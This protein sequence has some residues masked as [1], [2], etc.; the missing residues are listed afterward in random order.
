MKS[1][2]PSPE[3]R[4]STEDKTPW[5]GKNNCVKYPVKFKS[6][7]SPDDVPDQNTKPFRRMGN[8]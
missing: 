2:K 1:N 3:Q 7:K 8:E 4:Y 6:D 5:A